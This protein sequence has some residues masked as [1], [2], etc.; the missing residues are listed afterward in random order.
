MLLEL[1]RDAQT[2]EDVFRSL[3]I[4][5]ERRNRHLTAAGRA[6]TDDDGE[7]D[8]SDEDDADDGAS[9]G[10]PRDRG[11]ADEE[12]VAKADRS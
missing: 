10:P 7:E 4:G 3:T 2:L 8:E 1:H 11:G 6:Q 5:D 9:S 12:K